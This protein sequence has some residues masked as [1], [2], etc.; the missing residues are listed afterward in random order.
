[1][2]VKRKQLITSALILGVCA[3]TAWIISTQSPSAKR[4]TPAE[5]PLVRVL[6]QTVTPQPFQYQLASFGTVQPRTQ[7][8]LVSQVS[9]VITQVNP[10]FR[11]GSFFNQGDVLIQIDDRDYQAAVKVAKAELLQAQLRLEEEKA[12]AIQAQTDWARLG[13]GGAAPAL[14]LRKPQ[15]AAAEATVYSA[16]ANFEKAL[17]DLERTQIRAPFDG[18][19]KNALVDLG[20]FVNSNAQLASI[21]A[22]DVVEVRLPLKNSELHLVN[23]PEN[24]RGLAISPLEFPD[25]VLH[26]TLGKPETW[27][28]KIVRT[29]AAI[30]DNSHQLYVVAQIQD[31]FAISQSDKA[32]L[33]IGQYVTATI[34]GKT[35]SDALVV[36]TSSIYQGSFVYV[37][38]EDTL[39][40]KNVSLEFQNPHVAVVRDGLAPDSQLIISPLGQVT[41]GTQVMIM[42]PAKSDLDRPDISLP[43]TPLM[44]ELSTETVSAQP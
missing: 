6:S 12:R 1:M 21:F 39:Q 19:V 17:L 14:V 31:P 40:R 34:Q 18:R 2:E 5:R 32:S 29:E 28:G 27:H 20:Q 4:Q 10:M 33:K 38:E 23:L 37:V 26:S 36:P 3:L 13:D 11:D 43:D 7:S 25:V 16:Q 44:G 41:S 8:L 42:N 9:G 22:T 24:Y 35:A 30:D 15:L